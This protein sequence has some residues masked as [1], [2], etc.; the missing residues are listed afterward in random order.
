MKSGSSFEDLPGQKHAWLVKEH[1]MTKEGCPVAHPR[2]SRR[3]SA[4]T[5]TPWPS[6]KMKRSH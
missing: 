6:G 5:M 3:P 4:S 1:D 2:L